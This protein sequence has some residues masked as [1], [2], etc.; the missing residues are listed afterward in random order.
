MS[1]C[2]CFH[3]LIDTMYE[4]EVLMNSESYFNNYN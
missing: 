2:E 3:L 4:R 1:F